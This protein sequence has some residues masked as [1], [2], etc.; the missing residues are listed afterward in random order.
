MSQMSTNP[1]QVTPPSNDPWKW[2]RLISG[3]IA[4]LVVILFAL[5]GGFAGLVAAYIAVRAVIWAA[6]RVLDALGV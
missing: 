1:V 6:V 5:A 4:A 2:A 3:K